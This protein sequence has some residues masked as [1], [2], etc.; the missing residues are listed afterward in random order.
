MPGNFSSSLDLIEQEDTGGGVIPQT[1]SGAF[2]S[3]RISFEVSGS[4]QTPQNL[5]NKETHGIPQDFCLVFF[6]IRCF[7]SDGAGDENPCANQY[8]MKHLLMTVIAVTSLLAI[9]G[10]AEPIHNA[11]FSGNIEAVKQHIAVGL[12]VNAMNKLT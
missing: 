2:A 6:S 1:S 4:V 7:E 5:L 12:D 11:A 10:F 9:S 3:F 8:I